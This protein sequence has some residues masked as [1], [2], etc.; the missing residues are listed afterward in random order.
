MNKNMDPKITIITVSYNAVKTI[1]QTILSVVNQTYDNIEY[2]II[3]GGST[4]G[5]VDIIKKYKDKISYWVS[6]PDKGIYDAMNKG[7]A[8]VTG[9][10][11]YFLGA[12]DWI[13]NDSVIN[14]VREYLTNEN[15]VFYGKVVLIDN[16]LNLKKV[17]DNVISYDDLMSGRMIHHQG[18]FIKSKVQKT[19]LFDIKYQISSDYKVVLKSALARGKFKHISIFIANVRIGGISSK[20]ENTKQRLDEYE[21]IINSIVAKEI[22]I[23]RFRK[24]YWISLIKACCYKGCYMLR[25]TKLIKKLLGWHGI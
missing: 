24:L 19:Y 12:D 1:E 25:T 8:K 18:I 11:I 16:H 2:I 9:D 4:D 6:E 3:D 21:D 22:Y 15:D 17:L 5:T 20:I 23:K 14:Q 10:W 13:Y 7:V